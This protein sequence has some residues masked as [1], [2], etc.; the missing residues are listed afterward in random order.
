VDP[1]LRPGGLEATEAVLAEA[2]ESKVVLVVVEAVIAEAK[3]S[4]LSEA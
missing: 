2:K 1:F 3:E 4:E